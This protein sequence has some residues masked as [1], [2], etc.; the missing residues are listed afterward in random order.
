MYMLT[1]IVTL[2]RLPDVTR[3][4]QDLPWA[5][6]VVILNVF[7]VANIPRAIFK[8]QPFYAFISSSCT[9]AALT[10]LFGIALFPNL[11]DSSLNPEWNLTIYNSSSSEKTLTIMQI[12]ALMG[13]PFVLTYTIIIYRVFRGKVQLGKF[14]Y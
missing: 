6:A 8:G 2:V 1:T 11:I 13:M 7:A 14:S 9:I 3:H 10:F 5:W 12:I 4:F